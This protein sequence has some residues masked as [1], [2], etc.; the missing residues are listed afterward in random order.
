M[1]QTARATRHFLGLILVTPVGAVSENS[2]NGEWGLVKTIL[3][4][5]MEKGKDVAEC[6][7]VLKLCALLVPPADKP[8][9]PTP[10]SRE[11]FHKL[12]AV[13]DVRQKA[14]LLTTLNF[15]MKSGEVAELN[16]AD[17]NLPARTMVLG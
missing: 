12:L 11:D 8:V 7:R 15:A 14:I 1:H 17:L 4:F 13:A 6:D 9:N 3:G 16:K 5:A 10:I 2:G